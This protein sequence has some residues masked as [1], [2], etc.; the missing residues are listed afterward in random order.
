M[1]QHGNYKL[2]RLLVK[3]TQSSMVVPFTV[4]TNDRSIC[5]LQ[6]LNIVQTQPQT[7]SHIS[8]QPLIRKD[9]ANKNSSLFS[10]PH[11]M[12]GVKM[13]WGVIFLS[14]VL[15]HCGIQA[16][17]VTQSNTNTHPFV[18]PQNRRDLLNIIWSCFVTIFAC[19]WTSVHPNIPALD[20]S[21][22]LV[23]SRRLSCMVWVVLAP[24]VVILWAIRQWYYARKFGK[25]FAG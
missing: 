24:E 20:D 7:I 13:S 14:V 8:S 3:F 4:A 2:H 23:I 6:H 9:P 15:Q 21:F 18:N 17:P 19:T 12:E 25:F 16:A 11:R 1:T 5:S 22:L 10:L